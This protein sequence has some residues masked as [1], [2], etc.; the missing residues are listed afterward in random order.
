MVSANSGQA[1]PVLFGFPSDLQTFSTQR[2]FTAL[3]SPITDVHFFVPGTTIAATT[4]AFGLVL[5]DVETAF[6]SKI[7]FFDQNDLL[8][9]S[10]DA[11]VAGNQGL[12]FLGAVANAGER[13]SRV[14]ITAGI[15]TLVANGDLGNPND[16]FVVMDDFLYAE[17]VPVPELP[18]IALLALGLLGFSRRRLRQEAV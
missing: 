1:S 11:M 7:E 6:S 17:T 10:R 9:Y 2:L 18:T 16:E 12:S 15:N 5:V 13:I 8:I 14:R 4:S 3:N